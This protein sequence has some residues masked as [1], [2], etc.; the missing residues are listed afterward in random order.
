MSPINGFAFPTRYRG[1]LRDL[2]ASLQLII[3]GECQRVLADALE[4]AV[5][6]GNWRTIDA[7]LQGLC[8]KPH[9]I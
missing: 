1:D 2:I 5:A 6:A 3:G 9:P 8:V 7:A 4:A